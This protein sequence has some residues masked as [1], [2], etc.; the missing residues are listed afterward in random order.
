MTN[1]ENI[2][3]LTRTEQIEILENKNLLKRYF[4]YHIYFNNS[5]Y[6]VYKESLLKPWFI[7][8]KTSENNY[9]I[10]NPE[11]KLIQFKT[12]ESAHD[13]YFVYLKIIKT[14]RIYVKQYR[15]DNQLEFIYKGV[16]RE[17]CYRKKEQIKIV[18][19][20]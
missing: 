20:F 16:Y 10:Y 3:V 19:F 17:V 1:Y 13:V 9:W 7:I 15:T 14:F 18:S 6:T 11:N 2:N 12:A 4:D 8:F 5:Q